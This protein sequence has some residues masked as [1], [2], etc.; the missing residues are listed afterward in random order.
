LN[1]AICP[2]P[3]ALLEP[4]RSCDA[5]QSQLVNV[6]LLS[7]VSMFNPSLLAAVTVMLLL[8]SPKRLMFGYL[9]GAYTASITVDHAQVETTRRYTH[10]SPARLREA[11]ESVALPSTLPAGSALASCSRSLAGPRSSPTAWSF[12]G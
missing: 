8:P 10:T 6:F 4:T 3:D 2:G 1:R 7:L 12:H 5:M 9:L 11:I